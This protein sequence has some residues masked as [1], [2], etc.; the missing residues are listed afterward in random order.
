MQESVIDMTGS[1]LC[2]DQSDK[3]Y[4]QYYGVETSWKRSTWKTKTEMGI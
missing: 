2:C 3:K 1:V 4:I